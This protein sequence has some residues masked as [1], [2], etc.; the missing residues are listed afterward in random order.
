MEENKKE[1]IVLVKVKCNGCGVIWNIPLYP[2]ENMD[3]WEKLAFDI[4]QIKISDME[5]G[6]TYCPL[7]NLRTR[8]KK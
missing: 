5:K 3:K 1:K 6:I 2:K 7:C 8:K 4:A